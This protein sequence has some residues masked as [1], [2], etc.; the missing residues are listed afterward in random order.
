MVLIR[1]RY[2]GKAVPK[3]KTLIQKSLR[4]FWGFLVDERVKLKVSFGYFGKDGIT[5]D[6]GPVP[7][8]LPAHRYRS[9][10]HVTDAGKQRSRKAR[11]M[12]YLFFLFYRA[13]WLH[14]NP[15]VCEL[16]KFL[17]FADLQQMWHFCGFPICG[18]NFLLRFADSRLGGPNF[19]AGL[20]SA[21]TFVKS[22]AYNA[23]FKIFA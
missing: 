13:G 19:F 16:K 10:R 17:K 15:Q 14:E 2:T 6:P 12:S 1:T 11:Y 3:D 22:L 8:A 18:T 23:V 20:T 7:P 5:I 9:P 4:S 21:N